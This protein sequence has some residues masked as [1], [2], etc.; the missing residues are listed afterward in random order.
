MAAC[1]QTCRRRMLTI[2]AVSAVALLASAHEC[3]AG[4]VA[5]AP[6]AFGQKDLDQAL[7]DRTASCGSSSQK[8]SPS[9]PLEN[10]EQDRRAS[11]HLKTAIPINQSSSNSS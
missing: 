2:A 6:L 3:K 11:D 1:F 5:P 10:G 9:I 8:S 7:A 4:I